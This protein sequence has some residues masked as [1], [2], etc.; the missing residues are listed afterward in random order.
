M[1]AERNKVRLKPRFFVIIAIFIICIVI[2]GGGIYKANHLTNEKANATQNSEKVNVN[3]LCSGDLVMHGPVYEA[4]ATGDGYDFTESFK[5]IKP[6]IENADFS[7]CSLEA[8]LVSDGYS[9]YPSF[10]CP[11]DLATSLK[12]VGYNTVLTSS[13]H[14][15][16]AGEDAMFNTIK[17]LEKAGLQVAGSRAKAEE[18][19]YSMYKTKGVK[20]AVVPYVYG[21]GDADSRDLNGNILTAKGRELINT[22]SYKTFDEDFKEIQSTAKAARKAG[23]DII[24]MYYHWGDEYVTHSNATQRS[25]AKKTVEGADV[26]I[27]LGSHPHVVQ[28]KA[29][30][31]D[32]TVYYAM[33]NLLSNQRREY[34][35]GDVHTEEGVLI[36]LD[37]VYDK[38]KDKLISLKDTA[39]PYW[40]DM[41]GSGTGTYSIIPLDD[42]YKNN[43]KLK[44]SGHMS[45]ATQAKK[46]IENILKGE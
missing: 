40:E 5:Y 30:I 7:F 17:V 3:I 41:Y 24:I 26:D 6:Y 20:I 42:D 22:F 28:E 23:A 10:R 36:S 34:M 13:N 15:F 33:G 2:A 9:G 12:S 39:I 21:E 46:N 32:T 44:E 27:I 19:R 18:P 37:A 31:D 38:G 11:A 35:D 43:E 29:K 45:L 8:P 25:I 14:T 1:R 16:D 4:A